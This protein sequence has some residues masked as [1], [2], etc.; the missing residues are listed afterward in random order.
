MPFRVH[1]VKSLG[2]EGRGQKGKE[3][4]LIMSLS[5]LNPNLGVGGEVNSFEG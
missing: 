1:S 5:P 3:W 2:G 4:V